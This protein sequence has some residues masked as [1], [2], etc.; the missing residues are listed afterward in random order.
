MT[1]RLHYEQKIRDFEPVLGFARH[2]AVVRFPKRMGRRSGCGAGRHE[3]FLYPPGVIRRGAFH[4]DEAEKTHTQH[5][6]RG[7]LGDGRRRVLFSGAEPARKRFVVRSGL[8]H[9]SG[10]SRGVV[11]GVL[12]ARLT[13]CAMA[14]AGLS[15]E[16]R[17]RVFS[18]AV[19]PA[20]KK[21]M[22]YQTNPTQLIGEFCDSL[23]DALNRFGGRAAFSCGIMTELMAVNACNVL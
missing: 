4:G 22:L 10:R 20:G 21:R 9:L 8:L 16:R 2:R 6:R 18:Q 23:L 11:F 13:A 3:R 5:Y 1:K 19:R 14:V 17:V 7:L 12:P 15:S